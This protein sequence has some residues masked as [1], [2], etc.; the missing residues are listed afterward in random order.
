MAERGGGGG[1]RNI[2]KILPILIKP[3]QKTKVLQNLKLICLTL[4]IVN[5]CRGDYYQVDAGMSESS[6][7]TTKNFCN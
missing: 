2:L 7:V 3:L 6:V 1:D 4:P 5:I